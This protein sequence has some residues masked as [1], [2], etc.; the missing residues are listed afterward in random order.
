MSTLRPVARSLV[1]LALGTGASA[2]ALSHEAGDFF[3]RLGPAVV[4]PNDDS[5][6]VIVNGT[7]VGGT[8]VEVDE[9]YSLGITFNYMLTEHWGVELLA[10]TPFEH[11]ID[12]QGLEGLGITEIGEVTHLPPT[13]S[14]QYYPRAPQ[15]RLQPYVG[16][17]V[18]YFLS[19]DEE[20]SN[21]FEAVLGNSS[22]DTDDSIGLAGQ[23][24]VDYQVSDKWSLNA[25]V[26]YISV[27]TEASINTPTAGFENIS[28]DVDIDPLTWMVGASYRF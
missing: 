4:A 23:L 10:S 7:P 25:A 26:W 9:G 5:G 2:P 13:L 17:G 18:N 14:L 16:L 24:G 1:L 11:D 8:G 28:V 12:A 3:I 6:N 20:L 15:A 21:G 19:F 22:I 27:D